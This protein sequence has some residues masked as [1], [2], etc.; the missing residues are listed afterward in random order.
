MPTNVWFVATG[1]AQAGPIVVLNG[2]FRGNGRAEVASNGW[3]TGMLYDNCSAPDGLIEI[4]NRGA[5]GSGHG[6]G[7]RVGRDLELRG[8][9][10]CRAKNPPGGRELG[11]WQ[12]RP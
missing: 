2:A 8:E 4:R 6:W 9:I 1:S 10:L 5:M 12:P 7:A 11:D 3:S